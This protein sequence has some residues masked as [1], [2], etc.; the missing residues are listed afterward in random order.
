MANSGRS[1]GNRTAF[2]VPRLF[3]P[4]PHQLANHPRYPPNESKISCRE[5]A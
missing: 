1:T 5:S 4:L 3:P 2:G